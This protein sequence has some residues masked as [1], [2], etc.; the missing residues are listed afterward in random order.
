M[1][2]CVRYMFA[3]VGACLVWTSGGNMCWWCVC[4]C[5][6]M[7][8]SVG[9]YMYMC[10][11]VSLCVLSVYMYVK[12]IHMWGALCI[13]M[14]MCLSLCVYVCVVR[15]GTRCPLPSM[16]VAP[17]W[18]CD[19]GVGAS[20]SRMWWGP[21]LPMT[22]PWTPRMSVHTSLACS[23]TH[24]LCLFPHRVPLV[25]PVHKVPLGSQARR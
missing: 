18:A 11:Y 9:A 8:I 20:L 4:R 2:I 1:C 23:T 15:G 21:R 3:C 6:C 5:V 22:Y 7:C 12:C 14:C 16:A 24:P 10:R 17:L 13:C 25:P 19:L